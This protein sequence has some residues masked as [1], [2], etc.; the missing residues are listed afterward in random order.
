VEA[1]WRVFC[2]VEISREVT[3]RALEHI[4]QLQSTQTKAQVTWNREGKFHLTLKFLGH[5]PLG[6]VADVTRACEI[7]TNN[8][9]KF[10][11]SISGAGAFPKH[12]PPR[13]LWIGVDDAEGKLA[14][15]QRRL[16]DACSKFGF[17]KEERDFHPHLTIAR[18]RSP[19]GAKE[20]AQ[21]HRE[22]GFLSIKIDISEL[23]VFRSELSPQGA[24]YSVI[25]KQPLND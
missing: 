3:R 18:L 5:I 25:S 8:F 16:D 4:S 14:D 1:K 2:A 13:V 10:E 11:I 17:P 9:R 21:L 15:L 6:Q 23:L 19:Q 22:L 12:G 24:R 20:L 7:A